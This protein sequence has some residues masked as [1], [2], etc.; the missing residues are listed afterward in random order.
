MTYYHYYDLNAVKNYKELESLLNQ[1]GNDKVWFC[2][3][4]K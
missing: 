1:E 2:K 4:W 3:D